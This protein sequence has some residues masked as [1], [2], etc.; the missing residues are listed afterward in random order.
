MCEEGCTDRYREGAERH[1]FP[2]PWS[3]EANATPAASLRRVLVA[4]VL[5]EIKR[6]KLFIRVSQFIQT[7]SPN[8]SS[9]PIE[10]FPLK[11]WRRP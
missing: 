10:R 11:R 7:R 3:V 4:R 6:R 5:S 1:R 9:L 2:P 8:H